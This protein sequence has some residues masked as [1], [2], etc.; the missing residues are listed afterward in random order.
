MPRALAKATT[1]ATI[2]SNSTIIRTFDYD[3]FTGTLVV[4]LEPFP[5]EVTAYQ[6]SGVPASVYEGL[7]RARSKGTY[8]SANIRA[9]FPSRKGKVV[10]S[11]VPA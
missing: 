11:F 3:T 1:V 5:N 6:Y 4:E 9:K 7:T 2:V 8:F 10:H